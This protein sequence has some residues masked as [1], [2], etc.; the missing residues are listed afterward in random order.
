[1][2]LI[3]PKLSKKDVGSNSAPY[4]V[5]LKSGKML[6]YSELA[7]IARDVSAQNVGTIYDRK[8]RRV[9]PYDSIGHRI[10]RKRI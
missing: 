9:I 10:K 4:Q 8:K 1:M 7:E 5:V 3:L 2:A 6:Y